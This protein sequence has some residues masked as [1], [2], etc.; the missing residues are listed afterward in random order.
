MFQNWINKVKAKRRLEKENLIRLKYTRLFSCIP[1]QL[2]SWDMY[3]RVK[4]AEEKE[5]QNL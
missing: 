4:R 5:I 1:D 2:M 3:L